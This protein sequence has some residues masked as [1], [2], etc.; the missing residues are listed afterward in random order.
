M[1]PVYQ[2]IH[3]KLNAF[4]L[5][6]YLHFLL[7]N[8]FW[9]TNTLYLWIGLYDLQVFSY[10]VHPVHPDPLSVSCQLFRNCKTLEV[11]PGE[12]EVYPWL[13]IKQAKLSPESCMLIHKS[14][15]P[16]LIKG[17]TGGFILLKIKWRQ[18]Q[19]SNNN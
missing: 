2:F 1:F 13:I 15:Q 18:I 3:K 7:M 8:F 14:P 4:N 17:D 10:P 19:G 16:P 9:N 12:Q 11:S 6:F 5:I